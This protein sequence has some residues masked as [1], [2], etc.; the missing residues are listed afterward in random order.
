ME[1]KKR[2]HP[3]PLFDTMIMNYAQI[4][5]YAQYCVHEK[6]QVVYEVVYGYQK[7]KKIFKK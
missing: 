7:K 3:V 2:F 1:R 6:F 5:Y 4:P